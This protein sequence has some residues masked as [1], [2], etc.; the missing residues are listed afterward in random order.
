M[1]LGF[2]ALVIFVVLFVGEASNSRLQP[3]PRRRMPR[4]RSNPLWTR[5]TMTFKCPLLKILRASVWVCVVCVFLNLTR[6]CQARKKC[7]I[8][9]ACDFHSNDACCPIIPWI[10]TC[11]IFYDLQSCQLMR[12]RSVERTPSFY[13][14]GGRSRKLERYFL[15]NSNAVKPNV[16]L[17]SAQDQIISASVFR[18]IHARFWRPTKSA[19]R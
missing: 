8:V 10:G 12:D 5:R 15:H 19:Q 16:L 14:P 4:I 2:N 7:G 1:G 18:V 11:C 6:L 13:S 3:R 17:S 9:R